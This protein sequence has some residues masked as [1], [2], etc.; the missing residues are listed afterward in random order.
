MAGNV[1][2]LVRFAF[3]YASTEEIQPSQLFREADSRMYSAKQ[4]HYQENRRYERQ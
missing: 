2:L 1:S 4:R 3:G